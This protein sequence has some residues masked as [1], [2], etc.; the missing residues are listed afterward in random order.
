MFGNCLR[1]HSWSIDD[2]NSKPIGGVNINIIYSHPVPSDTFEVWTAIDNPR[3]Q[4]SLGANDDRFGIL[5]SVKD[6][7]L[8]KA[9][10]Y[11]YLKIFPF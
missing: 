2:W 3:G 11:F 7:F 6:I 9:S 8:G 10:A 4:F 1:I 5:C